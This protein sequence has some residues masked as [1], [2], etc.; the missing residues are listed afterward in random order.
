M[1]DSLTTRLNEIQSR[2]RT[3]GRLKPKDVDEVLEEILLALVDADVNLNVARDFVNQVRE[4]AIG[5]DIHASLNATQQIAKILNEQLTHI[6]GGQSVELDLSV[7]SPCVILMVGLQGTGKTTTAVKLASWLKRQ[8]QRPL[9]VGADLHRPAAI[10][11]LQILA[12]EEDIPVFSEGKNP[13]AIASGAL[14][15]A[16]N[17]GRNVIVCDTAGR[18]GVDAELMA[19][20]AQ[21]EKILSPQHTLLVLDS[22]SGQDSLQV[23]QDF[24]NALSISGLILTK[25][26]GDSRGGVALSAREV[27]GQP[28]YFAS[29]GERLQDFEI[30]H[31]DRLA[32]RILGMGDMLTLIEKAE[33]TYEEDELLKAEAQVEKMLAGKVTLDDFLDQMRMVQKIG[34]GDLVQRLPTGNELGEVDVELAEKKLL[35]MEAMISSMT[36]EEKINPEVIDTSRRKRIANGSGTSPTDVSALIRDFL[37]MRK[38]MKKMGGLHKLKSRMGM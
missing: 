3:K 11:Q 12:A 24:S 4:D 33:E 31:P 32:Q 6:L 17:A 29:T 30:F 18:T 16:K 20:L 14:K 36:H 8:K 26:D 19:E 23:S 37:G 1:F 5:A 34:M 7:K 13:K 35:K 15:A 9:L 27:V 25:L 22:M 2:L 38:E 21:I 10:E 28:I